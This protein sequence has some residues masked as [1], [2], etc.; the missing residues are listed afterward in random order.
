MVP[1]NVRTA[2]ALGV[3]LM[4]TETLSQT[5]PATFQ[6]YVV[7][8]P[9]ATTIATAPNRPGQLYVTLQGGQVRVVQKG[10]VS[11]APFLDIRSLTVEDGERGLLGLVFDPQYAKN[12]RLYVHYTDRNGNTVLA[13]YTATSDFS[14][15]DPKSAKVL[16]TAKQPFPNHNGG[17]LAFGPDGFLYLGLGDGGAAGDPENNAQNLA[18]PL[19]KLLRFDVRG[20]AATPAARNPFLDRNGANPH[21]WAYGLRNPWRF[22]FDRQSGDLI[23]A[24]VGQDSKEEIDRQPKA[25]KGGENYGWRFREGDQ[26][27]EPVEKCPTSGLVEPVLTYGHDEGSS[28]TGGYVYR[29]KN[30]PALKG[31]Y[32]FG[33]FLSG[34]V[35]AAPMNG[36]TWN[37]IVLGIVQNPATFGEDEDGELYVAEYGTGQI[38]KLGR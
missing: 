15:T 34:I 24:D 21:I 20:N 6:P 30:V 10:K 16:F 32:V 1:F 3:A 33:D 22:S 19:G 23:I 12:R 26:C 4:A 29:G 8:L 38:L 35:W 11:P 25:S 14:R 36:R 31:Q 28:T 5:P 13:R 27:Y 17:Q 37:K 9:H 18:S 2:L 7:G